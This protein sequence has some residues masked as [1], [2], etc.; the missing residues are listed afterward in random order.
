VSA[1]V[2]TNDTI[3]LAGLAQTSAGAIAIFFAAYISTKAQ[4]DF[5]E[6]QVRR[7]LR[8][9]VRYSR[10]MVFCRGAGD[11]GQEDYERQ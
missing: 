2:D 4:K 8:R 6:N 5:F 10:N 11:F 1:L 3:V 9:F 7:R